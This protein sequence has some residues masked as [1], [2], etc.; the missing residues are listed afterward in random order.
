M[1]D[2]AKV[3]VDIPPD[4]AWCCEMA[5]KF[6]AEQ[7]LTDDVL[8]KIELSLQAGQLHEILCKKMEGVQAQGSYDKRTRPKFG[9]LEWFSQECYA[10]GFENQRRKIHP[11]R[12]PPKIKSSSEQFFLTCVTGKKAKVRANF[13]EGF[14]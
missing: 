9:F 14:V 6:Q 5:H 12:N 4:A 11:K 1:F 3:K 10:R 13:S 8:S 2:P 7:Y